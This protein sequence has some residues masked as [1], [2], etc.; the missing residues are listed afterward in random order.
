M[1]EQ[2]EQESWFH[3]IEWDEIAIKLELT[4]AI[5]ETLIEEIVHILK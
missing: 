5:F 1:F 4:D 3:E 2:Q